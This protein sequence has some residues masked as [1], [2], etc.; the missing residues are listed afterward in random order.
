MDR[1]SLIV[2]VALT[3]GVVNYSVIARWWVWPILRE[4]P[5]EQALRP[6]LIVHCFRYIGLLMIGPVAVAGT[7]PPAFA[8]PSAY[9]DFTAA[10]LAALALV[11][12][13]RKWPFRIALVWLFN[14]EGFLDLLYAIGASVV[15]HATASAGFF[16]FLVVS[17]FVPGL[18][19]VHTLIFIL[20]L[21]RR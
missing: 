15:T 7:P 5:L 6:L 3:F 11:G 8:Y 10:L 14:L 21:R 19:V 9:G 16:L 12:L 1:T 13:S 17:V 18:L 2:S 4:K 20:L